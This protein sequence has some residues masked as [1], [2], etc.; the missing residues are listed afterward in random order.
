[1]SMPPPNVTGKLHMGHAMF[2]TLQDIMARYQRMRG[3]PTLWLP[4]TD[5]AGIA[6]QMV[7]EKQLA[8]EG[9]WGGRGLCW[10]CRCCWHCRGWGVPRWP[11][12][13]RGHMCWPLGLNPGSQQAVLTTF[14]SSRR[15]LARHGRGPSLAAGTGG[16]SGARPLRLRSGSGSR[17]MAASS[18]SSCGAWGPR[19]TGAASGSRWTRASAVSDEPRGW[20]RMGPE[21]GLGP[22][23]VPVSRQQ[24]SP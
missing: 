22:A 17:S 13:G 15:S 21:T 7:V 12:E 16:R 19:A 5:H 9:R 2:A 1:M 11:G 4:G 14:C 24:G 23:D 3:R 10:F 6:T 20:A 18:P 8:A